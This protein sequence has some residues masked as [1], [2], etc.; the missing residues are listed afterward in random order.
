MHQIHNDWEAHGDVGV[1][2]YKFYD[3]WGA[4]AKE[5]HPLGKEVGTCIEVPTHS[6]LVLQGSLYST[7]CTLSSAVWTAVWLLFLNLPHMYYLPSSA[8]HWQDRTGQCLPPV[9]SAHLEQRHDLA[10]I[11][12]QLG[13]PA[14]SALHGRSHKHGMMWATYHIYRMMHTTSVRDVAPVRVVM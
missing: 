3:F 4:V 5:L 10:F 1:D 8:C 2:S 7:C 9:D 11:H 14:F 12:V 6:P 13:L